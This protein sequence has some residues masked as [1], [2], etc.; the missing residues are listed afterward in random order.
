MTRKSK[1]MDKIIVVQNDM[2]R[3]GQRCLHV[4]SNRPM[5]KGAIHESP[6]PVIPNWADMKEWEDEIHLHHLAATWLAREAMYYTFRREGNGKKH[7]V[8]V[9]ATPI[10]AS[11]THV[12]ETADGGL[13]PPRPAPSLTEE[14]RPEKGSI[15]SWDEIKVAAVDA[16]IIFFGTFDYWPRVVWVR[17]WPKGLKEEDAFIPIGEGYGMDLIAVRWA[18]DGFVIVGGGLPATHVAE[19]AEGGLWPPRLVNQKRS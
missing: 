4:M 17:N 10:P 5:R 8:V 9:W 19:P 12:A 2:S 15:V 16:A 11:A 1:A 6:L 18:M 3:E 7:P 13:R 14:H